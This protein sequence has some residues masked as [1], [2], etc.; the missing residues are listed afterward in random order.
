M[1][2]ELFQHFAS[3]TPLDMRW[4]WLVS[5]S[6]G[7]D[8]VSFVRGNTSTHNP[9]I[10]KNG[11]QTPGYS[12]PVKLVNHALVIGSTGVVMTSVMWSWTSNPVVV[13]LVFIGLSLLI[14]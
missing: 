10:V 7:P 3:P 14:S 1:S 4:V 11:G 2:Q 9:A 12:C 13:Q 6:S 5:S 8:V